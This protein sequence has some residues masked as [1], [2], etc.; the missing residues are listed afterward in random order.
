MKLKKVKHS[1]LATTLTVVLITMPVAQAYA[2]RNQGPGAN[3]MSVRQYNQ[4]HKSRPGAAKPAQRP[5]AQKP[6]SQ[7]P[8]THRPPVQR[9]PAHRPPAHRPPAHRP[10]AYRPPAYKPYPPR[11]RGRYYRDY[12]AWRLFAGVTAV[13]AIGTILAYPPP[14]SR[15]IVVYDRTYYVHDNVYYEPVLNSG[16]VMYQV[17]PSPY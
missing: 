12:R 11:Y 2:R 16:Q 6:P 3:R 7:K 10:P 9:P 5:P 14:A 4:T 15:T 13:I 1:I 8:P 17:V